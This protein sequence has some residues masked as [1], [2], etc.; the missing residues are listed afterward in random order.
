MISEVRQ[1]LWQHGQPLMNLNV[2]YLR[3]LMELLSSGAK[4]NF[5][6]IQVGPLQH[7]LRIQDYLCVLRVVFLWWP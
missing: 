4:D 6:Q 3:D 1:S 7:L 5:V 2:F